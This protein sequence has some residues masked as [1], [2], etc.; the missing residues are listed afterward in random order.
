MESSDLDCVK[1]GKEFIFYL[2]K[3]LGSGAFSDVYLGK[4]ISTNEEVAIKIEPVK[5]KHPQIFFEAK[6]YQQL[7]GGG[8]N[9]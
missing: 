1:I 9:I 8:N 3:K 2:K 6:I 7:K 5:S 4:Y